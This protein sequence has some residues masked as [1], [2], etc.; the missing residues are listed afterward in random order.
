MYILFE[1]C[2]AVSVKDEKDE[3][4]TKGSLENISFKKSSNVAGKLFR[5][6]YIC[7]KKYKI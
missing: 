2:V 3:T 7:I 6:T 5:I 4:K 1:L